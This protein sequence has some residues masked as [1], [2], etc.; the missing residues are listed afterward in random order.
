MCYIWE[1]YVLPE[2]LHT[3][4]WLATVLR[5]VSKYVSDASFADLKHTHSS[6]KV[7]WIHFYFT[8]K[9]QRVFTLESWHLVV[10]MRILKIKYLGQFR[11]ANVEQGK[12]KNHT[13]IFKKST[14]TAD[15]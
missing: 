12:E 4:Y 8:K 2:V 14:H 6:I 9:I 11:K 1:M 15:E 7:T 3:L 13:G 5:S 10:Y